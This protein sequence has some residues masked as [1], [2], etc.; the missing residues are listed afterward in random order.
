M[1]VAPRARLASIVDLEVPRLIYALGAV[2]VVLGLLGAVNADVTRLPAFALQGELRDVGFNA[3]VLFTGCLGLLSAAFAVRC[4]SLDAGRGE[5]SWQWAI[6]AGAFAF[7]AIDEMLTFHERIEE[8]VGVEFEVLYSPLLLVAIVAWFV[9]LRSFG[10]SPAGLL[11]IGGVV[12]WAV[13]Q[14]IEALTWGVHP[15][16]AVT[17]SGVTVANDIEELLEMAGW[18]L[19]IWAMLVLG[20]ERTAAR[21]FSP[22]ARG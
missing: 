19:F 14:S 10:D 21:S 2:I 17:S 15:F 7:G 5:P 8:S 20:R 12:A 18:T 6:L 13:A 11:W 22:P 9:A 1:S 3:P 4:A 16:G